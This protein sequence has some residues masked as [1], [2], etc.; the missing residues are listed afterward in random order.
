MTDSAISESAKSHNGISYRLTSDSRDLPVILIV[1]GVGLNQEMWRPWLSTLSPKFQVLTI[2][3]YGHGQS[4]N[5][6]GERSVKDFVDQILQLLEHLNVDKFAIA[7]FSLGAI[8]SQAFA[9]LYPHRLTHLVLLHSVYQRTE[10]QCAGVRERYLITK[11]EGSMATVELAIKRWYTESYQ[12]EN[13]DKMDELRNVFAS[14]KGDGYLKS[15]YLFGNAEPEMSEYRIEHVRCPS[16]VITGSDDVGSTSEMSRALAADL[17][18][19]EL[20][21]NSKHRHMGPAEFAEQMSHQVLEFLTTN[22]RN[23]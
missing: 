1:H 21:I 14:H 7:G 19:A 4:I 23:L 18:N 17:P 10:E 11:G 3:L 15:Y 5:P 8:I 16:L 12:L 20:I 6:E 22:S 13:P 9:S 2:D